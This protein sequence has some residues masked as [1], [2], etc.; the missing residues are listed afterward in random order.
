LQGDDIVECPSPECKKNLEGMRKTL[1]GPDG[2]S[3]ITSCIQRKVSWKQLAAI[4]AVL[5]GILVGMMYRSLDAAQC[6]TKERSENKKQI[7][8][9]QKDLEHIKAVNQDLKQGQEKIKEEV[10]DLKTNQMTPEMF[11]QILKDEIRRRRP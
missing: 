9:I 6:A 4:A 3:G 1:Y 5:I 10:Q 8:V 7:E 11:R 2:K